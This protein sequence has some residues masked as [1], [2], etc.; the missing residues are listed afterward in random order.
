MAD[1]SL[2]GRV[3]P[4]LRELR[5][6]RRKQTEEVRT[7]LEKLKELVMEKGSRTLIRYLMS[8][9]ERTLEEIAK[10]NKDLI[11]QL[12]EKESVLETEWF[13][14]MEAEIFSQVK[15]AHEHLMERKDEPPSE[16]MS[17]KLPSILSTLS[18]R[19][20]ARKSAERAKLELESLQRKK[21]IELQREKE[22]N[23]LEEEKLRLQHEQEQRKQS[24]EQEERELIMQTEAQLAVEEARTKHF[25]AQ[26]ELEVEEQIEAQASRTGERNEVVAPSILQATFHEKDK[27]RHEQSPIPARET[28]P[29]D[30]VLVKLA[31]AILKSRD[32]HI[33]KFDGSP[34]KY[35]AFRATFK[36]LEQEKHY[37]QDEL[38]DLLLTHITG[39]AETALRGILP[40]SGKYDKDRK[41]VV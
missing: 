38:L 37:T 21:E 27:T 20:E 2:E 18:S 31:E 19:I 24:I 28:K 17:Q 36:K 3:E 33:K 14:R 32:P 16:A 7:Q 13:M 26:M 29:N 12:N 1:E 11:S 34:S 15:E 9:T 41:S 8:S 5:W 10:T 23:K 25:T 4:T 22:K 39:K 30:D 35:T 40:G 6:F